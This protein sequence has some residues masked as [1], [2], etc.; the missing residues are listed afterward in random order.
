MSTDFTFT[1]SGSGS[2]SDSESRGSDVSLDTQDHLPERIREEESW[3]CYKLVGSKP[4]KIPVAPRYSSGRVF[5]AGV[6]SE[7]EFADYTSARS[8]ADMEDSVADVSYVFTADSSFTGIDLDDCIVD[9]VI[10]DWAQDIVDRLDSFTEV[11]QSG[12]GLHIFVEGELD[13]E[14]GNRKGDVE[15][16]SEKRFF[17]TTGDHLESTPMSVKS[18]EQELQSVQREHLDKVSLESSVDVQDDWDEIELDTSESHI[19]ASAEDVITT[20]ER[21]SNK[22][23]YL[24]RDKRSYHNDD[25]SRDDLAYCRQLAFWTQEDAKLIEEIWLEHS[26]RTRPKTQRRDYVS[27]TIAEAIESNDETYSGS[28]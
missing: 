3:L 24:H 18:R 21:Y 8:F 19:E 7:N 12:T 6:S 2:D 22:F 9:G 26:R 1:V 4:R 17:A 23:F 13:E 11:S 15:M 28:Y 16:Y 20:A 27:A 5:K 10:E 14:Y 25:T